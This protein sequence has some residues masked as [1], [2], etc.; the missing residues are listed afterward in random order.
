MKK[1]NRILAGILAV[2]LTF[3]LAGCGGQDAS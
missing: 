1:R 3:S 2:M